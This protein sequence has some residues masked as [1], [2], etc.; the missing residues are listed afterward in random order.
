MGNPKPQTPNPKPQTP[1]SFQRPIQNLQSQ[2]RIY[3]SF[4]GLFFFWI[5]T[6]YLG[7]YNPFEKLFYLSKV[8]KNKN[9]KKKKKM[10]K[11]IRKIREKKINKNFPICYLK[12]NLN[13]RGVFKK[14]S[15]YNKKNNNGFLKKKMNNKKKVIKKSF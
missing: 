15:T 10:K 6:V 7:K 9:E 1:I 4:E 12:C 14:F 13:F 8:R 5:L 11:K 2:Q 3:H